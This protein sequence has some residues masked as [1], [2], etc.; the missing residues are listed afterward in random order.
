MGIKDT[1]TEI[2]IIE[3]KPKSWLSSVGPFIK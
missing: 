3:E 2:K 1:K